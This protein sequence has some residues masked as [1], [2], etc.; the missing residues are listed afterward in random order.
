M[1]HDIPSDVGSAWSGTD[2]RSAARFTARDQDVQRDP[3]LPSAT[4]SLFGEIEYPYF[5]EFSFAATIES[6]KPMT[7]MTADV[8]SW[9]EGTRRET[10][11]PGR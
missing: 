8:V 9:G 1:L 3:D 11:Q 6:T 7:E 4:S 2:E 5:E 10:S